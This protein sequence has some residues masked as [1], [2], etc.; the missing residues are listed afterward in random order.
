M[1]TTILAV[2]VGLAF[3]AVALAAEHPEHPKA[4]G[5]GTAKQ[6]AASSGILDGK[7]FVG[8]MGT[9]SDTKGDKDEFIFEHGK[10]IS[11]ACVDYGFEATAYVAAEKNGVVTFTVMAKNAK[12]QTMNWKG[13]AKDG[14]IEGTTMYRRKSGVFKRDKETEYWFKGTLKAPA[15]SKPSEHPEHPE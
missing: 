8:E 14:K 15:K 4:E 10:F 6:A 3:G 13:T 7:V 2:T 9:K 1:N 12:A 11:T 5:S